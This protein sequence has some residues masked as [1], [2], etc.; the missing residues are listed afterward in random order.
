MILGFD[1]DLN[2]LKGAA[3]VKTWSFGP[4]SRLHPSFGN[5]LFTP[6]SLPTPVSTHNSD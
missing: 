2:F 1:F 6:S 3:S 4:V 5:T